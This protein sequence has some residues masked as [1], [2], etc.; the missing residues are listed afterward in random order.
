MPGANRLTSSLEEIQKH[1]YHDDGLLL[2]VLLSQPL[3]DDFDHDVRLQ[4]VICPDRLLLLPLPLLHLNE[5]SIAAA[6]RAGTH[7]EHTK[8]TK[9]VASTS[10]ISSRADFLFFSALESEPEDASFL[11]VDDAAAALRA[12]APRAELQGV[13]N[14]VR[15]NQ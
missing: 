14:R 6:F 5:N 15:R 13:T 3:G 9:T 7:S 4:P 10:M 2:V 1:R 11:L 8:K 12:L